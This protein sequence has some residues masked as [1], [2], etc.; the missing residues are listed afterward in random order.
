MTRMPAALAEPM[1]LCESSTAAAR[2]GVDAEPPRSLEVDVRCGLSARDLLRRHGRAEERR[3]GPA[4]S[5]TRSISWPVRRRRDPE[6]PARREPLDRL[7]RAVDQR[8]LLPVAVQPC[9]S[10]TSALISSG[11]SRQPRSLVHVPRPLRR[12]HPHH[13][14]LRLRRRS[15]RRARAR[16]RSRTSSQSSSVWIRT[17]SRSKTTASITACG[18]ADSMWTSGGAGSPQLDR[19]HLADEER[20]V[21][22]RRPRRPAGTRASRARPT[23]SGAP[24]APRDSRSRARARSAARPA[25][26]AARASP[27]PSASRLSAK[28]P[29]SPEQLVHRRLPVDGDADERRLERERDERADGQA[30]SLA[31]R[32]DRQHGNAVREP[33]HQVPEPRLSWRGHYGASRSTIQPSSPGR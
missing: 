13:R 26:S 30:E 21:A 6:R 9:G 7:D 2:G 29:A 17:P 15:G 3:R 32:V 33:P 18:S 27:G 8:Q 31:L 1:P 10:T 28:P 12:A 14:P 11:D 24:A 25:R 20:V 22:G 23:S 4:S 16:A 5:S 19:E